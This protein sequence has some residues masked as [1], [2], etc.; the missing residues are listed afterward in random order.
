MSESTAALPL[1]SVRGIHTY[2]G[3]SYVLQGLDLELRA[4]TI[5]GILGRNGM[6]KT[7]LCNAIMGIS[8][9]TAT[10]S[11]RFAGNELVAWYRIRVGRAIG[12]A[13]L[14]ADGV[15]ARTDGLTSLAVVA[16][17]AGV[18]AGFPWPTRSWAWRSPRR[19][20]WRSGGRPPRCGGG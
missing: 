16:G 11:I 9:P 5:V 18:A 10:G 3:D 17:A 12:S 15:H 4:G 2:Y 8:P 13:A 20:S 19:S 7:T 6:G 14:V 1:L